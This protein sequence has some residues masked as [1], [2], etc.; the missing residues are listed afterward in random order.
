MMEFNDNGTLDQKHGG[1]PYFLLQGN[2]LK[3]E[4]PSK[5]YLTIY[6]MLSYLV[7]KP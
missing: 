6:K 2:L 3:I 4:T 5:V 1:I 7:L